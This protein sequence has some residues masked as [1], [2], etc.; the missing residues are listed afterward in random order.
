MRTLLRGGVVRSP[1]D[2]AATALLVDD[3]TVAFVGSDDAALA[4]AGGAD[5]FVPGVDE[6]VDLDGALVTPAFVDSHVHTTETGLLLDGVDLHDARSVT[7]I[8]ARVEA[9]SRRGGGRP[10]LGQGWDE[11]SLAEGRPPTRAELDRASA[12]GVVYLARVDVHSAVISSALAAASGADAHD[13]W[14]AD[15]RVERDAHHAARDATRALPP[16]RRRD[17]QLLA[18]RSAAAHGIATVHEAAAPHI[19]PAD[20][21][22]ALVALTTDPEQ[23][24]PEVVAYWGEL[25]ADAEAAGALRDRFGPWLAGLA[26]DLCADGSVGSRTAAYRADYADCA[27]HRGHGYL[28]GAQVRDHVVACTRVGLQAGFHVI[29]DAG[30]DAVVEGLAL[31]A[32]VVGAP[33]LRSARHRLEHVETVDAAAIAVLA[34]LGVAASV[35]PAFDALWG[36]T[37]GLYAAR[38]GAERALTMNPFAALAAAGVPLAL[39]SDSP[40]TPFDPWGAVRAC[41]HHHVGAQRLPADVAFAAHTQGAHRAARRD[42]EGVLVAG[43]RATLAVWSA[44][45]PG[46]SEGLPD[47]GAGA[48]SPACLLT[49][50]AGRVIH[51]AR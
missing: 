47:L 7:E 23:R 48:P 29:G 20:D 37:D 51:D 25:A 36:G 12:G 5:A 10:I 16:G 40:V 46:A 35:Q 24:L 31:A 9:A 34:D 3:G 19:G 13:G 30:M 18:L 22:R 27:G 43:T 42:G 50:R 26:G 21:L 4:H 44:S 2:P 1:H 33:A 49:M 15:G 6:V 17:L 14:S 38:L 41:V 28:S 32:E 11:R 39:G 45:G 8:L